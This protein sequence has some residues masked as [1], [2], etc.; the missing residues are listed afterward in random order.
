MISAI[1]SWCHQP[2]VVVCCFSASSGKAA[3][4]MKSPDLPG[5]TS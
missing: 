5:S 1:R 3:E 2:A 4:L